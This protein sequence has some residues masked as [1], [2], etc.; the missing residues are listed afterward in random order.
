MFTTNYGKIQHVSWKKSLDSMRLLWSMWIFRWISMWVLCE[1]WYGFLW[2]YWLDA[3]VSQR[4]LLFIFS[5]SPTASFKCRFKSKIRHWW[6]GCA[7]LDFNMS[8]SSATSEVKIT[9]TQQKCSIFNKQQTGFDNKQYTDVDC[10]G[11]STPKIGPVNQKGSLWFENGLK[12]MTLLETN[13]LCQQ[14]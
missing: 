13:G 9:N 3:Y 1:F 2:N 6:C 5:P 12:L 4:S 11:D 8:I 7:M 10:N 14:K